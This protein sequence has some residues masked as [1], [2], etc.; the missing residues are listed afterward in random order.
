MGLGSAGFL[1]LSGEYGESNATSRSVQRDDA[2][3]LIAA[4]NTAVPDP[5]QIWGQPNVND[6]MKLYANMGL[7]FTPIYEKY[8]ADE[9]FEPSR[10]LPGESA[11]TPEK[12]AT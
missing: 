5:A 9:G 12:E 1:N 8:R 7:D 6:D 2:A 3:A 10:L 11:W 4:G